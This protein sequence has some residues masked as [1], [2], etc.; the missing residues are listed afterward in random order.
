MQI[1]PTGF[2]GLVEIIPSV[3]H[4][5]RGWFFEFFKES[6]FKEAGFN[7]SFNQENISFSKKGVIRGLHFQR[8]PY[9]QAKLVA[10]LQGSILDI[11]VDIRSGSP[12]FGKTF[13]LVLNA[14]KHN[15]L[16]VPEGFAHGFAAL[17]DSLFMYK[18]TNQYNKESECGIRWDDPQL[19]ITWPFS[20][21]ILS[22]KD[23]GL[24]TLDELLRNSL[25]S[26][27]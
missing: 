26:R 20:N 12:T 5:Q 3:Y 22:E 17:E 7:Y 13:S 24:P 15:M 16:M 23:S 6:T 4:D 27:E 18:C 2:D 1:I 21:P 14:E 25:I 19:N 8:A 10:V 11:V 9:E